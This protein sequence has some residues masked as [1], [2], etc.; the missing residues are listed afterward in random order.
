MTTVFSCS[1]RTHKNHSSAPIA[2]YPSFSTVLCKT[3]DIS[4]KVRYPFACIVLQ[5]SAGL[6]PLPLAQSLFPISY[7]LTPAP[8]IPIL[9]LIPP[10]LRHYLLSSIPFPFNYLQNANFTTLLF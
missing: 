1:T 5:I 9:E 6:S 4:I 10:L 7:P 3:L 8:P 2:V